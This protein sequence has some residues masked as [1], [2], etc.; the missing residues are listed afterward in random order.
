MFPVGTEDVATI[1]K[2]PLAALSVVNSIVC[3]QR[4][5]VMET[6]VLLM[7][8]PEM[9]AL[10]NKDLRG[11]SAFCSNLFDHCCAPASAMVVPAEQM[12]LSE[13]RMLSVAELRARLLRSRNGR[14]QLRRARVAVPLPVA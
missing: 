9:P 2:Q 5:V 4:K 13:R 1:V 6:Y 7:K 10:Q 14:R 12:R 3:E 11:T 8:E